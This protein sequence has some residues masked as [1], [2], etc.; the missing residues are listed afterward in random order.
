MKIRSLHIR[1]FRGIS[2]VA[3]DHLQ[4]MVVI[5]GPNGCGKSCI[6]DAIRL[7]KSVYGGYQPNEIHQWLGEFQLNF[8][9]DPEAFSSLKQ[10]RDKVLSIS[11]TFELQP[12]ERNYLR[13]HAET[14]VRETVWRLLAPEL[15][16]WSIMDAAPLAAQVRAR[17]EQVEHETAEATRQLLAELRDE[18]LSAS[19]QIH[20]GSG[21]IEITP[22][23][24]LEIVFS[25]YRPNEIGVIEYNGAKRY[26]ERET[27]QGVNLN[28]DA[29]QH[30][31][32]SH[33][34]LYNYGAKY[35]NVKS[36]LA[37]SYVKE[38]LAHRAGVDLGES[39]SLTT[40]LQELFTQFFPD[41]QFL[42]P[43]AT[44]DG[45]LRFP[46]RTQTG[47]EHDL[48]ELSSG[49]KEVLFGYLRLRNS[50]PKNSV[51]LLDEPE[52]HLNPRLLRGLP[53]FY[54]KHLGIALNNQLW[55]I[56][57]SDA[58]LRES[59]GSNKFSVF[60]MSP[61]SGFDQ[62]QA[63]KITME[64][65]MERAIVDLVG[66]LAS[67]RPGAKVVILEG[68]DSEFDRKMIATLFP[69]FSN[70]VNTISGGNKTG[71]QRLRDAMS[72]AIQAGNIPIKV[73]SITDAD[74][75]APR[76]GEGESTWNWDVYHI[77]N[78]LLEPEIIGAVLTDLRPG[79]EIPDKEQIYVDLRQA[80][81]ECVHSLVRHVLQAEVNQQLVSLINT[82]TGPNPTGIADSLFDVLSLSRQRLEA[83][84]CSS[85]SIELLRAREQ[86]ITTQFRAALDSDL[87]RQQHRGRDILKRFAGK[88]VRE[89]KYETLRNL[90]MSKMATVGYQPIGMKRII[91][92]I[93]A[94]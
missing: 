57:H 73:F 12:D 81:A 32:R 71:V 8:T 18:T 45:L 34:A 35:S 87:W 75:D 47:A 63:K 53:D 5:A 25:V 80:A 67:Y 90:I 58:L 88:H 38:A 6:L 13:T 2:N 40:T 27:V 70:E 50:A 82:K 62:D 36:E 28:L 68:E 17:Q 61:A 46:V 3:L 83:A 84:F 14:L 29:A 21:G 52:L 42:G 7:L 65:E 69:T 19:I 43:V 23:K 44:R 55:L 85:F 15:Q 24:A 59:V 76:T 11:A 72:K 91:D 94:V 56:T 41:K 39:R 9:Q 1:N 31:Q 89:V 93:L 26:Y 4:D 30:Q 92:A 20:S 86:E 22:S 66:D 10:D 64:V 77:E 78:Y 51:I 48:N 16:G 60:H 49:E 33:H 54:H 37:S 79:A 74:L